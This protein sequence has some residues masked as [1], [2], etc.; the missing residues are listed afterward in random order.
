MEVCK[1]HGLIALFVLLCIP[2]KDREV[3]IPGGSRAHRGEDLLLLRDFIHRLVIQVDIS[4]VGDDCADKPVPGDSRRIGIVSAEDAVFHP[5]RVD[6]RM[7][8]RLLPAGKKLCARDHSAPPLFRAVHNGFLLCAGMLRIDILPVDARCHQHLIPRHGD[9]RCR[10]DRLKRMRRIPH[11]GPF[12]T[13]VHVV[14]HEN[15]SLFVFT[16]AQ[17]G[18][19]PLFPAWPAVLILPCSFRPI[20]LPALPAPHR[21]PSR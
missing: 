9:L 1:E 6:A 21:H 3:G 4:R 12:C 2:D 10:L 11:P 7:P 8:L 17:I 15:T 14:S 19:C 5:D 13:A 20:P 18:P 16:D